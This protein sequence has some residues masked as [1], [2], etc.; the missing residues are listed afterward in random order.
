MFPFL[1]LIVIIGIYAYKRYVPVFGV[2]EVISYSIEEDVVVLDLRDYQSTFNEPISE[3]LNIPYS[4][5]KRYYKEIPKRK[6]LII[7]TDAIEKNLA[8]RFL[9]RKK[10]Q[11]IGFKV[12]KN[13]GGEN[14]WNITSKQ[15]IV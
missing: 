11:V 7:A 6:L 3:S 2:S 10:F 8:I 12:I 13:N 15:K 5:L 14:Q 9:L 1:I 4:Y